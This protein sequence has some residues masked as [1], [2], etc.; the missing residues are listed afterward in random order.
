MSTKVGG[1]VE[2]AGIMVGT[3]VSVGS[4]V[5][6]VVYEELLQLEN[7]IDANIKKKNSCFIILN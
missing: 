7:K 6:V 5:T 3:F 1:V 4:A 2:V